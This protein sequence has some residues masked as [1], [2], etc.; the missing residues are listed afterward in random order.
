[1]AEAATGKV[2]AWG[3]RMARFFR[4]VRAELGKVIWPNRSEIVTYT[5]VVIVSVL[6]V[7]ALI[8]VVDS[9]ISQLLLLIIK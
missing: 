9:A 3:Q 8:W 1:M 7:S 4:E 6:L 5:G 2:T